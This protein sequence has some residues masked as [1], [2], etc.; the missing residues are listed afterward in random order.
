LGLSLNPAFS[1]KLAEELIR[2][3]VQW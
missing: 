2:P 1:A 3:L